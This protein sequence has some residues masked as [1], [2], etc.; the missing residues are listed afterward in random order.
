MIEY[1]I[2][3]PSDYFRLGSKVAVFWYTPV[4]VFTA[5]KPP[6]ILEFNNPNRQGWLKDE[7]RE[8]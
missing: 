7:F 4:E 5:Y 2:S 6:S 3:V 1:N 8:V